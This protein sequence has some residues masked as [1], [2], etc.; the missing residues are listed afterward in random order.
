MVIPS[1]KFMIF[2]LFCILSPS[3]YFSFYRVFNVLFLVFRVSF[4]TTNE[5]PSG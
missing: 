4:Q 2:V 3:E 1:S 5:D